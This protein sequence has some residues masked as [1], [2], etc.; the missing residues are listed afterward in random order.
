LDLTIEQSI[1]LALPIGGEMVSLLTEHAIVVYVDMETFGRV[2]RTLVT[3]FVEEVTRAAFDAGILVKE[4]HA[5]LFPIFTYIFLFI[6]L[7]I[8]LTSET[9][10]IVPCQQTIRINEH[11]DIATIFNVRGFAC[12]AFVGLFIEG[13]A[14]L[15]LAGGVSV[16][17]ETGETGNAFLVDY[18]CAEWRVLF[19]E[20]G[21]WIIGI[22]SEV[23]SHRTLRARERVS[24]RKD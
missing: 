1:N 10:I 13:L 15:V 17:K 12:Q 8:L 6:I 3:A 4:Q 9:K 23:I 14:V 2:L 19:A 11:A 5:I 24:Y 18:V 16:Q 7:I 22:G 21:V 20:C